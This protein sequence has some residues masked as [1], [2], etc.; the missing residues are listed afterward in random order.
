MIKKWNQFINERLGVS[1]VT[2]IYTDLLLNYISNLLDDSIDNDKKIDKYDVE[3]DQSYISRLTD[4]K[5]KLLMKTLP[6]ESAVGLG[7]LER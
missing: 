5:D 2:L 1:D 7:S 3:I 6:Q 4:S